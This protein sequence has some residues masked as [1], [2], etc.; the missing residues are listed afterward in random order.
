MARKRVET[1]QK[2]EKKRKNKNNIYYP[3]S[4]LGSK[5][6]YASV[7]CLSFRQHVQYACNACGNP[8]NW[9]VQR[10]ILNVG[11]SSLQNFTSYLD[12]DLLVLCRKTTNNMA[13]NKILIFNRANVCKF[14][15]VRFQVHVLPVE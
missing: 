13:T 6:T 7:I 9:N 10:T 15:S 5:I 12:R 8:L 2:E 11:A 14:Y 1:P 3:S 4:G